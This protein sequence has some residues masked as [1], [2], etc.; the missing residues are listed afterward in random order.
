[1]VPVGWQAALENGSA[2]PRL[3]RLRSVAGW[4]PAT[5]LL[6]HPMGDQT[7][8]LCPEAQE[9]HGWSSPGA[10]YRAWLTLQGSSLASLGR[11]RCLLTIPLLL[12]PMSSI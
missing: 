1:M 8:Q 5:E 9:A 6:S 7:L 2:D 10:L 4:E 11:G 12:V 3:L